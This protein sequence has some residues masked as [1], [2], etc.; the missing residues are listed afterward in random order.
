MEYLHNKPIAV[1]YMGHTNVNQSCNTANS[2][3]S[4]KHFAQCLMKML[5]SWINRL[6]VQISSQMP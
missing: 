3:V 1:L 6:E 2:G 5:F 4:G